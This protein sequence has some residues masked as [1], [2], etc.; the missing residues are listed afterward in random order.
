MTTYPAIEA[1]VQRLAFAR[2]REAEANRV[3][4][5][6][7]D[8][9][10]AVPEYGEALGVVENARRGRESEDATLRDLLLQAHE[11]HGEKKPHPAA[12]VKI[13][14]RAQYDRGLALQ[15]CREHLPNALSYDKRTFEAV[16]KAA[17]LEFVSWSEEPQTFIAQDLCKYLDTGTQ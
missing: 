16:A 10:H 1:A 5:A 17:G 11:I 4:C 14:Q 12:Y 9:L 7:L 6:L 15:Y 13:T 2:Q 3:F 8:R